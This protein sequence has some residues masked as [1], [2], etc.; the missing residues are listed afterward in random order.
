MLT[1][2]CSSYRSC[3]SNQYTSITRSITLS[4]PSLSSTLKIFLAFRSSIRGTVSSNLICYS[5]FLIPP[6]LASIRCIIFITLILF[7]NKVMPSYSYYIKK[8]LVYI[9]IISLSSYQPLSYTKYIKSNMRLFYNV[10]SI[11]NTKYIYY[12]I[13]FNCLVLCLSCC[14]VLDLICR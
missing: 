9:I 12:P 10:Y 4:P 7:I 2:S 8:G 1:S 13:L 11:S 14:R 6:L 5:L 3:L